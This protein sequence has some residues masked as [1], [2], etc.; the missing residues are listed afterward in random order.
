M[1]IRLL[2]THMVQESKK[3]G[4]MVEAYWHGWRIYEIDYQNGWC[5]ILFEM[6]DFESPIT[7]TGRCRV[8]MEDIELREV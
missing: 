3:G 4:Q 6:N 8:L 2:K 7:G 5:D 1:A